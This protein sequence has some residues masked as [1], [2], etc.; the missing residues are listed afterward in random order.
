MEN[1]KNDSTEL[2]RWIS[3]ILLFLYDGFAVNLAFFMAIIIRFY[4]NS[5]FYD[6][7][8]HYMEMFWLFTPIYT[9]VC[10]IVFLAFRLY[11]GVWRY[12]GV[13]DVRK[14]VLA[15]ACTCILQIAG[16]LVVVGRM[17]ISYYGMGAFMQLLFM[18]V[19]RIAPRFII[20]SFG[21]SNVVSGQGIGKVPMMI[22]GVGENARIIQNMVKKDKTTLVRPVCV[23]DYAGGYSGGLI[24]GLPVVSG[25]TGMLK[26]INKYGIKCV[27]LAESKLSDAIVEEIKNICDENDIE[28]RSFTIKADFR[29]G[30]MRLKDVLSMSRG[31]V[32]IVNEGQNELFESVDEAIQKY[33]YNYVID[34][35]SSDNDALR[36]DVHRIKTTQVSKDEEWVKRYK[37]ENGGEV[38]FFV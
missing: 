38:S 18:S 12:V 17:P 27:V 21:A 35:I 10:L 19:P 25:K 8:A 3:R 28:L 33:Q 26:A 20:E 7:G 32:R 15:N 2:R 36:I 37:E 23:V 1:E 6:S 5:R 29:D 13:N 31:P 11:S 24:N 30:G 14:L 9:A 22:V 34:K 4:I 16:S